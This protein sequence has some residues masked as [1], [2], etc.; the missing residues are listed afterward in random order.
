MSI[1][2]AS[3]RVSA[4]LVL[5][6][7]TVGLA[8]CSVAAANSPEQ[9][10]ADTGLRPVPV[11]DVSVQVGVGSPI[12]VDLFISGSWPDLC[13]QLAE[14]TQRLEGDTIVISILASV[15]DPD[16]P[17]DY[18]GLPF[19]IALPLNAVQLPEG[20]YLVEVNGVSKR[21]SLEINQK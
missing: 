21:L 4:V 6:L 12:P 15:A 18:L 19:R 16:C 20:E 11:S 10:S 9:P 2:I 14:I 5:I 8:A 13:A 1:N 7:V 3:R 17:P